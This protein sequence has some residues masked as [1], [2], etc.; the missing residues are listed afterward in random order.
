MIVH[1]S[2]EPAQAQAPSNVLLRV[3]LLKVG[4]ALGSSFTIEVGWAA[5]P[6]YGKA[7]SGGS[8]GAEKRGPHL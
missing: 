7:C 4:N 1:G 5:I 3:R 8:T 2:M 6:Y